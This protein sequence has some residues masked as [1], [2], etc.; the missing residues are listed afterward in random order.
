MILSTE[1]NAQFKVPETK[2]TDHWKIELLEPSKNDAL[3]QAKK[4]K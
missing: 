3:I 1:A 4:G 2:E